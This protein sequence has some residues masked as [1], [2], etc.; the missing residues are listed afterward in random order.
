[1]LFIR[2]QNLMS[3]KCILNIDTAQVYKNEADIGKC[4]ETL[5]PKFNL[6]RSDIF[7]TTKIGFSTKFKSISL[8]NNRLYFFIFL[9]NQPHTIM[10]RNAMIPLKQ[11]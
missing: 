11:V 10:V 2:W 8:K 6:K 5:L 9:D 3:F 7:I 4:L 1:M